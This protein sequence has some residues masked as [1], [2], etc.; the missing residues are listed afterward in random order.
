MAHPRLVGA[1]GHVQAAGGPQTPG[2]GWP[3]S[4]GDPS[5]LAFAMGFAID[6]ATETACITMDTRKNL[7]TEAVAKTIY[8]KNPYYRKL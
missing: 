6:T 8:E 5:E 4:N 2:A 7:L 3:C 1:L